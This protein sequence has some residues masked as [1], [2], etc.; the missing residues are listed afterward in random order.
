[1]RLKKFYLYAIDKFVFCVIFLSYELFL[2]PILNPLFYTFFVSHFAFSNYTN[3]LLIPLIVIALLYSL[4][5]HFAVVG[6]GGEV[7]TKEI[8]QLEVV[9]E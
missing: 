4:E 1:M 6:I 3:L 5:Y 7:L 9:D 8:S 2:A